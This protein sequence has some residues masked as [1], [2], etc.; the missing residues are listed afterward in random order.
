MENNNDSAILWDT[1]MENIQNLFNYNT[2]LEIL[3]N[4]IKQ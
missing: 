2:L 4:L 3:L 1:E